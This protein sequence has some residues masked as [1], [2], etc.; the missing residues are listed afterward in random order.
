MRSK[1]DLV[2]HQFKLWERTQNAAAGV[3]PILACSSHVW[4]ATPHA[5]PSFEAAGELS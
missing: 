2:D 4:C 1:A 3:K 5:D